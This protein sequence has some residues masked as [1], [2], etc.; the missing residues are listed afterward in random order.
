MNKVKLIG[1][2]KAAVITALLVICIGCQSFSGS[3]KV[4]KGNGKI[5]TNHSLKAILMLFASRAVGLPI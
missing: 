5:E 4:I 1:I 3:D 2:V